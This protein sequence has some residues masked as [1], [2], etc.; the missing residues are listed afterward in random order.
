MNSRWAIPAFDGLGHQ[1]Q[2][3]PR[4]CGEHGE[5]VGA[6][7]LA[8]K[9]LDE[10]GIDHG[11]AER[12]P[13][14]GVD[15]ILDPEDPALEQIADALT[16]LQKVNRGLQLN[17]RRQE[18]DPDLGK[19]AAN[20]PRDIDALKGVGRRH[21]DIYDDEVR[22]FRTHRGNQRPGVA[23]AL[24]HV[25]PGLAEQPDESLAQQDII[26]GH[27]DPARDPYRRR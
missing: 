5:R 10:D 6:T 24:D 9:F 17:V 26:I 8:Q 20:Y 27:D 23:D 11:P 2:N 1:R 7:L 15:E 3:L 19:L 12:D 14:E 4:S 16:A 21:P 25:V 13:F 22:L 18:Q